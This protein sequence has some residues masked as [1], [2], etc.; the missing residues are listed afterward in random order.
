MR[1][2]RLDQ[3]LAN[4]GY[5]SRSEAKIWIRKGR[6]TVNGEPATAAEKKAS[7]LEVRRAMLARG[8]TVED[9]AVAPVEKSSSSAK[10]PAP[11]TPE[12]PDL[13]ASPA[14]AAESRTARPKKS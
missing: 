14:V 5:C 7:V 11:D 13:A 10:S 8:L 6:V 3:I 2:R 4:F 1:P 12:G 9:I